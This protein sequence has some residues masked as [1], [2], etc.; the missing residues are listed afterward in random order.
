M[1]AVMSGQIGVLQ[2]N[3]KINQLESNPT[4]Q[5]IMRSLNP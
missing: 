3:P 5:S 1:Q 2:N 4:V